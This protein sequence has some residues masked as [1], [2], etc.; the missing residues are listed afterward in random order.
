M[1]MH[2]S[3][4]QPWLAASRRV[5]KIEGIL[6]QMDKRLNHLETEVASLGSEI[7]DLRKGNGWRVRKLIQMGCRLGSRH[8]GI[9]NGDADNNSVETAAKTLLGYRDS[10]YWLLG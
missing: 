4:V 2:S 6:E 10:M 7:Q 3:M 9:D 8:V 5:A 1:Q